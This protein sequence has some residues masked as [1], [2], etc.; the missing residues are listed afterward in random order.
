MAKQKLGKIADDAIAS[1]EQA[2]RDG[3]LEQAERL[4]G[5]AI[6]ADGRRVEPLVIKAAIR[7]M[8]DNKAGE[9]LM[10]ELAAPALSE[11]LFAALVSQYVPCRRTEDIAAV[12]YTHLDVYKRQALTN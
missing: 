6:S 12:S 10:A 4:S 8:K 3:D 9:R 11:K 5:V 7:R 1:A 2:L